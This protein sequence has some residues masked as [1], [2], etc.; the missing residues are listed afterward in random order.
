MWS[1]FYLPHLPFSF[2]FSHSF[3]LSFLPSPHSTLHTLRTPSNSCSLSSLKNMIVTILE[4][5]SFISIQVDC[6]LVWYMHFACPLKISS[7]RILFL[8]WYVHVLL[9][10][11]VF[12]VFLNNFLPLLSFMLVIRQSLCC[13]EHCMNVDLTM[14]DDHCKMDHQ[15]R[16]EG[17]F[18]L[19]CCKI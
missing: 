18:A 13:D 3:C 10:P 16:R 12:C 1:P 9:M 17:G 7:I 15:Y 5:F 14:N 8:F 2:I 6:T 4:P 11:F 19:S